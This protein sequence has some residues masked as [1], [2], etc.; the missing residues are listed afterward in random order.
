MEAMILSL[1]D[2]EMKQ[3]DHPVEEQGLGVS[4]DFL[5]AEKKYDLSDAAVSSAACHEPLKTESLSTSGEQLGLLL[6]ESPESVSTSVTEP[7]DSEPKHLTLNKRELPSAG[8]PEDASQ[9][10]PESGSTGLSSND[11]DEPT[12]TQNTLETDLSANTRATL[13]TERNPASHG[14]DGLMR[15]WDFNFFRN[16]QNR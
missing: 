8:P 16:N 4:P 12:S 15:R 7:H 10:V 1:K 13:T 9:S 14:M 6:L 2:M 11:C 5:T 3:P